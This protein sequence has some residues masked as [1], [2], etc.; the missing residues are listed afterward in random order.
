MLS[1]LT[2]PLGAYA[3]SLA[4]GQLGRLGVTMGGANGL[5]ATG[6]LAVVGVVMFLALRFGVGGAEDDRP[7][8]LQRAG[9]AGGLLVAGLT[10]FVN[11]GLVALLSQRL[12]AF[13]ST[14]IGG[15]GFLLSLIH[16]SEPT[17]PS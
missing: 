11:L 1:L 12:G 3:G 9:R 15:L 6:A 17:S 16:I 4:G 8:G 7:T 10:L 5:L 13:L 14:R 2:L